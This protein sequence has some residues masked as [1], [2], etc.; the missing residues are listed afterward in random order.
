MPINC[1]SKQKIKNYKLLKYKPFKITDVL[2]D[3]YKP[4]EN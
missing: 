3:L 2:L 4:L 1:D